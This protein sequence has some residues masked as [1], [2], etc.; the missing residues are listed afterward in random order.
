MRDN[1]VFV[2]T[3]ILVDYLRGSDDAAKY[4]ASRISR[5]PPWSRGIAPENTYRHLERETLQGATG[6]Q[7]RPAILTRINV[8]PYNHRG[9]CHRAMLQQGSRPKT[10]SAN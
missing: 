10:T 9:E 8:P 7:G 2:E 5:L 6:R 3:A 4:L 1:A